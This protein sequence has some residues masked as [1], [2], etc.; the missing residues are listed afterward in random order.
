MPKCENCS[1][2]QAKLNNGKLCKTCFINCNKTDT[3]NDIQLDITE[4]DKDDAD[5]FNFFDINSQERTIVDVLKNNMVHERKRDDELIML[6]KEQ[7]DF[8]KKELLQKN[9]IIDNLLNLCDH[10]KIPDITTTSNLKD[11]NN[12]N[13]NNYS[14]A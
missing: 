4:K 7:L 3:I 13:D 5:L 10:N 9:V 14:I 2:A 6:L 11:N 12:I 1:N 8:F